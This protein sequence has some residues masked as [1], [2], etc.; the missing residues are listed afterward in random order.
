MSESEAGDAAAPDDR[1]GSRASRLAHRLLVTGAVRSDPRHRSIRASTL[2]ILLAAVFALVGTVRHFSATEFF[3][4]APIKFDL[5]LRAVAH[6]WYTPDRTFPVTIIDI[7]ETTHRAWGSPAVTPREPLTRM[8][9]IVTAARPQAVVVD[10]D[11]SWGDDATAA[12]DGGSLGLRRFLEQYAGPAPLIFPKR[13][14]R[15]SDGMQRMAASPLDDLFQRNSS[16]AWAHADFQTGSGGAVHNW[17]DWLSVCT[18]DRAEWLP[19][20]ETTLASLLATLPPGLDR[21]VTPTSLGDGCGPQRADADHQRRLLIGPRITGDDRPALRTD[22]R[23]VSA[24]LL[25]DP[26]LARNDAQLFANRVVFIG[27]TH[28]SAGDEWLTPSGVLPG[29]ELLANTVRYAP[30]E[31]QAPGFLGR[32]VHRVVALLLFVFFA[33]VEWRFRGLVA[34]LVATAGTLVVV[35]LG[36]GLFEDL[37][38]LD[39]VEAAILLAV[40]YKAIETVL[41]FVAEVRALRAR[42]PA[43]LLG[44]L[45]A[46]GAACLRE[47]E[48]ARPQGG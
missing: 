41:E 23:S 13:L 12:A 36:L 21:P 26:Q 19:S 28:A 25:L 11:L 5:A 31:R 30:L 20:V 4:D 22:A 8:L 16:L 3:A 47:H 24:S 32:L 43:G 2:V 48:P 29:V 6:G 9:E 14:E 18:N 39:A 15:A 7:D 44:T 37:A 34:L 38:V 40:I 42:F 17:Q 33:A 46:L 35:A 10:I 27:A 1:P 45:R